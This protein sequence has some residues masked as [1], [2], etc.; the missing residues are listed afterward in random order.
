MFNPDYVIKQILPRLIDN[1]LDKSLN[2]RH[3]AILGVA[4]ILIGLSGNSALNKRD[5][6]DKA[7]KSL[8]IKEIQLLVQ[9]D[10]RGKFA[11]L[12]GQISTKDYLAG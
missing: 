1:C 6:L 12:Y 4:E 11:E 7:Y 10:Y 3:G 9:S 2:V 5:P 8:S